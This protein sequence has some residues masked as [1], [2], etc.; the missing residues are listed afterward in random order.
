MKSQKSQIVTPISLM[1][2]VF[3]AD[4]MVRYILFDILVLLSASSISSPARVKNT[5]F[6][7][8]NQVLINFIKSVIL[9]VTTGSTRLIIVCVSSK[10]NQVGFL[11]LT[12]YFQAAHTAQF[13]TEY[14]FFST[15]NDRRSCVNNTG[16][17]ITTSSLQ[18]TLEGKKDPQTYQER[19]FPGGK[20]F[21]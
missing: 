4:H 18:E 5:E 17:S 21:G 8:S 10:G 2:K 11:N 14:A 9:K 7:F 12:R 6:I 13:L 19:L 15:V 1:K 16:C 20:A 3:I